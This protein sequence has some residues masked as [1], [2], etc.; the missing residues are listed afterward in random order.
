MSRPK[1][2]PCSPEHKTA[3]SEALKGVAKNPTGILII[4]S[5]TYRKADLKRYHGKT[6]EQ[7]QQDLDSQ[8]GV[9]AICGNPPKGGEVLVY[10]HNHECCGGKKSCSNCLRKLLCHKCNRALG[11]F[12]DSV[13]LLQRAIEY[14]RAHGRK[15]E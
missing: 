13:V 12:N 15:P 9:C 3:I 8:G 2:I 1:G 5:I 6:I 4:R 14:L 11:F 10:D 7:Y